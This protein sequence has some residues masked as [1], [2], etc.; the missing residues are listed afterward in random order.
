MRKSTTAALA[1]AGLAVA[2]STAGCG[3]IND[4]T[5]GHKSGAEAIVRQLQSMPGISTV[6][7]D[8]THNITVGELIYFKAEVASS[9]TPEQAGAAAKTFMEQGLV[10]D[11][12]RANSAELTLTYPLGGSRPNYSLRNDS[13]AF[14]RVEP[15]W[16]LTLVADTVA[17][18][19]SAA[20]SPIVESVL[21]AATSG[22]TNSFDTTVT[23]RPEATSAQVQALKEQVPGLRDA[24]WKQA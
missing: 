1:V 16:D 20:H 5:G 18:W 4:L 13:S 7:L 8:Y 10:E 23:V 12:D 17:T 3:L 24:A 14:L 21:T 2:T 11:L 22:D 6:D 9:A 15:G 19:L